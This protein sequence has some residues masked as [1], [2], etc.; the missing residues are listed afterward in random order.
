MAHSLSSLGFGSV[1]SQ[2][3]KSSFLLGRL[4]MLAT[5]LVFFYYSS[6]VF[7]QLIYPQGFAYKT[8]AVATAASAK[9]YTPDK[10][11]WGWFTDS[12]M[13]KEPP[14][15]PPSKIDAKLLGVIAQGNAERG[16]GVA[17]IAIKNA[18]AIYKVDDELAP[19]ITLESVSSY[20]VTLRRGDQKEI[21]EMEKSE[22]IFKTAKELKG[23]GV[24]E[25]QPASSDASAAKKPAASS[26]GTSNMMSVEDVKNM[27][28]EKPAQILEAV[29]FESYQDEKHGSG[30]LIR[31]R[32]GH[33]SVL[34]ILG[35]D[36]EDVL[37]SINGRNVAGLNM[38][39]K[40]IAAM[41]DSGPITLKVLREGELTEVVVN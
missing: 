13:T 3:Q 22:N 26:A 40:S 5:L 39:P 38:N 30:F 36:S 32:E 16:R 29:Q 31:P 20:F 17:L 15:P 41:L 23:E 35:L 7:W 1:T 14:P 33:E 9:Q 34:D 25:D 12:S 21:L 27:L 28:A 19:G 4:V 24:D 2:L 8:Q 37:L 10:Q 6:V 11:S 18:P